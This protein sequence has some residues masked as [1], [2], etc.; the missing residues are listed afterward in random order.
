MFQLV[1]YGAAVSSAPRFAP[2]SL[3]CTPTT[4]TLSDAVAETVTVPET[5][6]PSAGAVRETVGSS[7]SPVPARV[8]R[9]LSNFADTQ[10]PVS[11]LYTATPTKAL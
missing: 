7:L 2:S 1:L 4:P 9:K 8:T 11:A 10:T 3:N 5:V 6:L